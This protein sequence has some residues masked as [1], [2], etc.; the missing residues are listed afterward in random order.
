M[1]KKN[2]FVLA[3]FTFFF[4]TVSVVSA[5]D[6]SNWTTIKL[7]KDSFKIPPKYDDGEIGKGNYSYEIKDANQFL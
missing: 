2:I 4:L 5:V 7:G 6:T 1:N 3:L